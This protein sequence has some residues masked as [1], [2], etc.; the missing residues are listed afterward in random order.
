MEVKVFIHNFREA[1]GAT[2]DLPFV[3]WYSDIP[4]SEDIEK[5]NGCF[6]KSFDKLK[7]GEQISLS[8]ER[9]GCMGGKFY[10]GFSEMH[11]RIPNFV[12]LKEKY[13]KTP[14]MVI[15]F[16]QRMK[17][18]STDKIYLN[19][20]PI[21]K[22]DSFDNILGIIFFAAPDVLSGLASWTFFDNNADDAIVTKFGSGCS[23]IFTDTV[24]ENSNN[25][26]RTFLGLFVPS[27]RRYIEPDI[28]SF[29]IP[30]SRFK[31]MYFTMRESCLFD[32][33][34]WSKVR[35]RINGV[36]E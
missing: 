26:R 23:S 2:V 13:K 14:E 6:F 15:D 31:E 19:I 8:T 36:L 5:I 9:I 35:N 25:G 34:A 12:S 32:T 20:S 4:I 30:M 18:P 27:V 16:I 28:L 29:A 1:F 11:E 7:E 10:T 33:P 3:F 24:V 17:V 22:I 21:D